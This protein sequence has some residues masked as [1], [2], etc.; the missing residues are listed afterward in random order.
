MEEIQAI[1]PYP[2]CED[3]V[4]VKDYEWKIIERPQLI[5]FPILPMGVETIREL[6]DLFEECLGVDRFLSQLFVNERWA[7]N[8]ENPEIGDTLITPHMGMMV[9]LPESVRFIGCQQQGEVVDLQ[10]GIHLIGLP[11]VPQIYQR[12]SDFLSADGIEWVK[13]GYHAKRV[14]SEDDPDDQ[15]LRAGQAIRISVTNAV[16]LDLRGTIVETL[17]APSVRRR[18]TLATSWGAMKR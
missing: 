6:Y 8:R 16:T 14:S 9:S 17:A 7:S 11:E 10:P 3:G 1:D 15:D 13:L 18:G 2:V 4:L 12:A 5:G